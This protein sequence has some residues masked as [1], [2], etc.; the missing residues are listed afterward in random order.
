MG[1]LENYKIEIILIDH[2]LSVFQT[3][4]MEIKTDDK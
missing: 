3:I 4:Y 1:L 2:L